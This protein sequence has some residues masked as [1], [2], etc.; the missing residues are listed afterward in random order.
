MIKSGELLFTKNINEIQGEC[1]EDLFI[2]EG[3][4]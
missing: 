3:T 2:E 4:K 1:L